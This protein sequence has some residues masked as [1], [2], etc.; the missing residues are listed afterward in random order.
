VTSTPRKP[1]VIDVHHHYLPP[2]I[3]V[4]LRERAGGQPRLNDGTV[5][6]SVTGN[7]DDVDSHLEVMDA[8]G[9]DLAVLS[10][11]GVSVYGTEFCRRLNKGMAKLTEA[12]P[13][14]FRG[15]LH[16]A[17]NEPEQAA[18]EISRSASELGLS[19]VALATSADGVE[20]DDPRLVAMWEIIARLSLPVI[21]HPPLGSRWAPAEYSLERSCARP[22]ETTM[23]MVRLIN[24]V[25]PRFGGLT[26][27]AP[28]CGGAAP[29]LRGRIEMFYD[30]GQASSSG[31]P[32][33]RREQAQAGLSGKFQNGWERFYFDT[34][35]TGGWAPI[36]SMTGQVVGTDRLMFGS[37]YP[38]ESHSVATYTELKEMLADIDWPPAVLAAVT[39]GNAERVLRI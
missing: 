35:G 3:C 33:T 36:V 29:C 9:V 1:P 18:D 17:I 24:A 25:L 11:S 15:C 38:L 32:R 39:G 12:E 10:Y 13:D 21:L 7:L 20:L 27:I 19:I 34:A 4:E 31:P 23:A 30:G 5:S 26:F 37:D 16:V 22:I 28:H 14:R 2:D 6:M 8:A